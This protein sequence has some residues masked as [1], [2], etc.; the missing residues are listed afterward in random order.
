[1]SDLDCFTYMMA[2][3]KV[4]SML[5]QIQMTMEFM[6]DYKVKPDEEVRKAMIPA[7]KSLQDWVK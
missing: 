3:E 2:N 5:S 4:V 6:E 7:I 1:M